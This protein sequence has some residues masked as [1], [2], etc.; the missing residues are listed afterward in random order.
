MVKEGRKVVLH[1]ENYNN[2]LYN[3]SVEVEND[4]VFQA[5][6]NPEGG[7]K[8]LLPTDGGLKNPLEML[9][10]G[11]DNPLLGAFKMFP[12]LS[13]RDIKDGGSGW[14]TTPEEIARREQVE[15]LKKVESSFEQTRDRVYELEEGLKSMEDEVKAKVVANRLQTF[16][17]VEIAH[18]R[19]NPNL[20]PRQIKQLSTE[21]M[22]RVFQ[23]TDPE[24]I[25]LEQVLK[26]ADSQ[27]EV[28]KIVQGYRQK[29][30]Q[31]ANEAN[32]CKVAIQEL[33]KFSFPNSNLDAI[34]QKAVAFS[35][36]VDTRLKSYQDQ[37]KQLEE[38]LNTLE[39]LDPQAL[40]ALRTTYLEISNNRF[41][42]T[43][44][45][46]TTGE[47]MKLKLVL[48]P[49]DSV[50]DK[51]VGTRITPIEV[52]VYGGI[53]VKAGVGLGFAQYFRRPQ[54]YYVRDSV[55]HSSNKDAFAPTLTSFVHFYAPS[56]RNV[57]L[58]GSF[59]VGFP[60]GGGETLQSVSFFLGPS[61]VFGKNERIVLST[62]IVGGKVDR[63][64][65]GYKTGDAYYSDSNEAP[66]TA[67]YELG[68]FLG[69]SFS[70]T[71]AK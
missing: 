15:A 8:G 25:G 4:Q 67:V 1:I 55:L 44:T 35:E 45:Q 38:R 56:R 43:Y 68:Y 48:T 18:L 40:A 49:V 60:I 58:A 2:Y 39:P 12:G 63:L 57:S 11:G 33:K 6:S 17:A 70:L 53:R 71:G 13:G 47:K 62:G 30:G 29:V 14:S 64:S 51:G 59:G 3:A 41:S 37:V 31:Y 9:F 19:Y 10:N 46:S 52:G 16:A 42:K 20:E 50:K 69:F 22:S 28:A 66:T 34:T 61:L 24:K 65:Q 27:Q 21:Y 23:E 36:V 32:A 54:Q 7:L 26:V 5:E